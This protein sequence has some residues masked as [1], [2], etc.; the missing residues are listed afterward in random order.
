MF[1][2]NLLCHHEPLKKINV[3]AHFLQKWFVCTRAAVSEKNLKTQPD[4]FPSYCKW[5][6]K[7]WCLKC[8]SWNMYITCVHKQWSGLT[9]GFGAG[10]QQ[11]HHIEMVT[12][13]DQDLQLRHQG[14]VLTGGST[15]CVWAD[16]KHYSRFI[17]AGQACASGHENNTKSMEMSKFSVFNVHLTYALSGSIQKWVWSQLIY[18]E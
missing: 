6:V 8:F 16:I 10:T 12:Y 7:L 17:A 5:W 3:L 1:I 15:L 13:M 14:T 2:V 4:V 11:I 9:A 18:F